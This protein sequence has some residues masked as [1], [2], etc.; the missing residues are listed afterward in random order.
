MSKERADFS[1]EP[2]PMAGI[3]DFAFRQV[4]ADFGA[5]KTWTEM[6]SV[7][8]ICHNNAKTLGM[9]KCHIQTRGGTGSGE[10]SGEGSGSRARRGE[11]LRPMR[12]VVQLFGH[13]PQLFARA[14][15]SGLLDDFHEI[16]INMGCPAR[17]VLKNG[18]GV[19]LMRNAELAGEI[20]RACGRASAER[21]KVRNKNREFL[22][23]TILPQPISVK[24]RLGADKNI[25]VDFA[26]NLE[27]AGA[28][29]L[30]VHGRLGSQGYSGSTDYDAIREVVRAVKIPVIANGDIKSLAQA[31]EVVSRTGAEGVM[32]GRA[33]VG[34]P[35]KISSDEK[36]NIQDIVGCITKHIQYFV[37]DRGE[38]NFNELK[39]HLIGYA[40]ALGFSK[41]QKLAVAIAKSM[42]EVRALFGLS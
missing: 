31:E 8:A 19:N 39:Q 17:K 35:W 7:S 30:I 12:T 32:I 15:G 21:A 42:G 27:A 6:I 33:L 26:R 23:R 36:P 34:S 14:I 41:Q 10:G 29:R 22:G 28:S 13:E 40:V 2:A 11:V 4:L 38:K 5:E 9:L 3:S 37:A 18:D 1:V 20:V 16:N 24:M 25:A